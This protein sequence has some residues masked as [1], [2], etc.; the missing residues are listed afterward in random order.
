MCPGQGKFP[1]YHIIRCPQASEALPPHFDWNSLLILRWAAPVL[2]EQ[3]RQHCSLSFLLVEHLWTGDKLYAKG[4]MWYILSP[5]RWQAMVLSSVTSQHSLNLCPLIFPK[6]PQ[7]T[8]QALM[9][10][11]GDRWCKQKSQ[12]WWFYILGFL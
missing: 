11:F 7:S 6:W 4:S 5:D 1:C 2:C 3:D 9:K 12:V 10:Q 8:Q